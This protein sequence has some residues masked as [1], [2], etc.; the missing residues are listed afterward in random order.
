MISKNRYMHMD[1]LTRES[2]AYG[3]L[4]SKRRQKQL[5]LSLCLIKHNAMETYEGMEVTIHTFTIS[6]LDGGEWSVSHFGHLNPRRTASGTHSPRKIVGT[7]IGMVA[8]GKRKS[9]PLSEI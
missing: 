7:R 6:T 1:S 2:S 3:T 8:V 4:H 9:L 5:K